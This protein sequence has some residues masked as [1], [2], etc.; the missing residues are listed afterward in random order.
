[1]GL[2]HS[3]PT[4]DKLCQFKNKPLPEPNKPKNSELE[5]YYQDYIEEYFQQQS[6]DIVVDLA[7]LKTEAKKHQHKKKLGFKTAFNIFKNGGY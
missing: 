7:L 3:K 5:V 2:S 4:S 6:N 1:M